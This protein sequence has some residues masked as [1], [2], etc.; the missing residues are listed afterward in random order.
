MQRLLDVWRPGFQLPTGAQR[1]LVVGNGLIELPLLLVPLVQVSQ[2]VRFA[3]AV[4]QLPADGQ[5]PVEAGFGFWPAALG[6]IG[7]PQAIESL[8]LAW[9]VA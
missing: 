6:G 7:L 2:D 1:L 9:P 4:A 8:P 5:A 3:Q